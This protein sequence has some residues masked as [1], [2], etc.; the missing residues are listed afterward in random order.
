MLRCHLLPSQ[1]RDVGFIEDAEIADRMLGGWGFPAPYG[2]E[3]LELRYNLPV[4]EILL[5]H[6]TRDIRVR[7]CGDSV[8]AMD[9]FGADLTYFDE[10]E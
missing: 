2:H 1:L 8:V 7:L 5:H 4:R 3:P 6:R 10:M 9:N